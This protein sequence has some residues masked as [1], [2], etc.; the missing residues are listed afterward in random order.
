MVPVIAIDGPSGSG[1]GTIAA[2]VAERLGWHCLDSGALYRVLGLAAERRRLD[3]D[4]PLV[5]VELAATLPVAFEAQ[6]VLLDGEDV[7]NLIRTEAAGLAASRVA[8][9]RG[10]RDALLGWQRRMAR[11]PGLV[12]DGR[13][14]GT[15]VFPDAPLKCFLDASPEARAMRRYKQLKEKGLDANLPTLVEEI[16]AR[17]QRD[18][19]RAAAP[20]RVADGAL[21]LDTTA[22]SITQ[23]LDQ[24]LDAARRVFGDLVRQRTSP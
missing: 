9:H 12:A 20:L 18:R 19:E 5:L 7:T 22:L 14:M 13:D 17:D 3:L 6:R 23:V 21:V 2:L 11:P 1:K 16:R 15:V 24:V 10:V 8:V 4:D